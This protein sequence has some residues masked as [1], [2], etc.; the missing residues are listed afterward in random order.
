MSETEEFWRGEFGTD[1]QRRNRGEPL[2]A[3]NMK[4]FRR[5]LEP[6]EWLV[7]NRYWKPSVIEFGAGVG[8]NLIALQRLGFDPR[9]MKAVEIN[10]D[11][12]DE[13]R[14][15]EGLTVEERSMFENGSFGEWDMVLSSGF[16]IHISPE[17]LGEAYQIL[18]QSCKS[19]GCLVICEYFAATPTP[20]RYRGHENR[21]WRRNYGKDLLDRFGDLSLLS[22]DFVADIDP[23]CP[24]D[25]MNIW[26]LRKK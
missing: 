2:I 7:D 4:F 15:I 8:L 10:H 11:A 26:I 24:R 12:C 9:R 21:L 19:G 18:Y 13:L 22:Y 1:Y 16:L 3:N 14:R 17:E 20:V 5:I 6:T 25:N 23:V